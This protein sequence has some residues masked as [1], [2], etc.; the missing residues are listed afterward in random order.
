MARP[1]DRLQARF[2]AELEAGWR[3]APLGRWMTEHRAEF[4]RLLR[5]RTPDGDRLAADFAAAGLTDATGGR[6]S[7]EG[8]RLT[9]KSV[10]AARRRRAG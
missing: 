6:P 1:P 7:G 2:R 3:G 10:R 5:G 8:V 4:P 9:W